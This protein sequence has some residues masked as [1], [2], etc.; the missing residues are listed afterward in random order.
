MNMAGKVVSVLIAL[1][2]IVVLAFP[3]A[4]SLGN[5]DNGGGGSGE[6]EKVILNTFESVY[7]VDISPYKSY[8][9]YSTS[10]TS[11]IPNEIS[12]TL[13]D[14]TDLKNQFLSSIPQD[15][16][17][18]IEILYAVDE[19]TDGASISYD[20][21]S[22][23]IR[24]AILENGS[25]IATSLS[26][27][28]SYNLTITPNY[29]LTCSYISTSKTDTI[30]NSVSDV[31]ELS[32]SEYGWV[33][34]DWE[35]YNNRFTVGSGLQIRWYTNSPMMGGF[36]NI[37]ITQDMIDEGYLR[38][39]TDFAGGYSTEVSF[40]IEPTDIEGVWKFTESAYE[41]EGVLI[42]NGEALDG[43]TYFQ[44]TTTYGYT[45][46]ESGSDSGTSV[47]GVAGTLIKL[48]PII[49]IIG[50][51]MTFIVPMVYKPN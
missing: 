5:T 18:T 2:F 40:E 6:S 19:N 48:V 41:N 16:N 22:Q 30:Q 14:L 49:L 38:I 50:L 34:K 17:R 3:I 35:T 8:Q 1:L 45:Q 36:K 11:T 31:T 39:S 10:N 47:G 23:E 32:T 20:P 25:G 26:N 27:V 7:G 42:Q 29:Q 9:C 37:V 12:Y 44:N 21:G 24:V 28:T 4:N 43:G 13:E 51:L 33:D 46:S 15:A